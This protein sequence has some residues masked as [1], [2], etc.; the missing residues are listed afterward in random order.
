MARIVVVGSAARDDVVILPRPLREGRHLD[1]IRRTR[2]LGGGGVNTAI[3]L[4]HAGHQ[5]CLVAPVGRDRSGEWLLAELETAGIDTTAMP[6]V[7][8][9]S[10]RSLVLVDPEGE[11]TIVN[12]H[13]CRAPGIGDRLRALAG[14]A[15]YVR[16]GELNLSEVLEA[17]SHDT[18][19]V[20]H[21][22]PVVER[23]RP[24]AVLVGSKP[25]L[26]PLFLAD[27]W[28][29]GRRIAGDTLRWVVVTRGAS[30]ADAYGPEGRLHVPAPRVGVVDT[31]GAGDVFAAGLVHGLLRGDAMERA[32]RTA[33][34]WGAAAVSCP[35]LPEEDA[36]RILA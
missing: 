11:R 10:T 13:R 29:A 30:G 20:A 22:P 26:T 2:R 19:V 21:V 8:G 32:L 3:P 15:V 18:L 31:T 7:A 28:A 27:P 16:S 4:R 25:D 12:L 9:D 23:S 17:R 5:V 6:R 33:V 36:I 1:A 24:A 34:S 14:D 35:G